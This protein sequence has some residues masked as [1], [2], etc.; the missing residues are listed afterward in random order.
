MAALQKGHGRATAT[1][2]RVLMPAPLSGSFTCSF[3]GY[4]LAFLK[5]KNR[6]EE[7]ESQTRTHMVG[8][9]LKKRTSVHALVLSVSFVFTLAGWRSAEE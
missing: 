4:A 3:D 1:R 5:G 8:F 6:D 7:I 9:Y 2:Q